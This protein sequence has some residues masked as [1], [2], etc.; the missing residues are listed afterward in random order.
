MA[1]NGSERSGYY[2]NQ[3]TGYRAFVPNA[4]P[5]MPAVDLQ[6]LYP[7]ISQADRAIARLDGAALTLPNP[8]LFIYMYVRKEAVVSSQIEGTQATLVDVLEYEANEDLARNPQE[9]MEVSNYVNAIR[10]GLTRLVDVPI[11]RRL[12]CE[13]HRPLL[14]GVRGEDRR[15]GEIRNSQNWIGGS[16]PSDAVFVPPPPHEVDNALADLEKFIHRD[17]G[18]PLLV[19]IGLIHAQFE[20][21]HPFLDGNGRVGRMLV[22]LLLCSHRVLSQPLLY[23]SYYFKKNRDEYYA[24]LQATRDTGDWEGWLQYFLLGVTEVADEAATTASQV[25]M[26]RE[27]CRTRVIE[28]LGRG[29]ASG[30]HLLEWLFHQPAVTVKMVQRFLGLS[31]AQSN[32]LTKEFEQMELLEEISG[33]A[34]DRVFL[35]RPYLNL[36]KTD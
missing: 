3:P 19:K 2:I 5:P 21:I 4:L 35:F 18:L 26:L 27:E 17:T 15:P 10:I 24:R 6:S 16:S 13:I 12:L 29:A 31:Y 32:A 11:S 23:L 30:L 28:E 25:I 20:T 33:R 14:A 22:T 9:A 36:F 1:G 7:Y 8:D 34:R